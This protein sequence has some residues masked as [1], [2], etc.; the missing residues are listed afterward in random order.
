MVSPAFFPGCFVD[1]VVIRPRVLVNHE[2]EFFCV[3]GTGRVSTRFGLYY[4]TGS[5][6]SVGFFCLG[7]PAGAE[8]VLRLRRSIPRV[9]ERARAR[10]N[11]AGL[12]LAMGT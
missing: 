11:F 10:P 3:R 6:R 1:A 5:R 12:G 2:I 9:L 4:R 8:S 7:G